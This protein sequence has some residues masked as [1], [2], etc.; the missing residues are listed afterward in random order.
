MALGFVL[1][2]VPP[3]LLPPPLIPEK[4]RGCEFRKPMMG[5]TLACLLRSRG[6][7]PVKRSPSPTGLP[8][9]SKSYFFSCIFKLLIYVK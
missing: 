8:G 7:F 2:K 5:T 1:M 6:L 4:S 3:A 9:R